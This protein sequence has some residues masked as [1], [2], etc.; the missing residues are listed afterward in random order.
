MPDFRKLS[1]RGVTLLGFA[2]LIAWGVA[3]ATATVINPGTFYDSQTDVEDEICGIDV[4]RDS[5]L[6]LRARIRVDKASDGEAFLQRLNTHFVDTFTNPLNGRSLTLE[7]RSLQNEL[8]ATHVE[9]NV[10]EFTFIEA[11]RPFTVRDS[12]GSIVQHNQGSIRFRGLLDTLGDGAPGAIALTNEI[13]SV[14]GPHPGFD[15][16][17]EEFC[18]MIE[19][20]LL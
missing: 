4:I 16:N 13:I 8:Q 17:E 9:G 1:A 10:Y 2:A 7:G 5:T 14:N 11:G 12:S 20:L 18:A 19:G 6:S 15:Q 3:P